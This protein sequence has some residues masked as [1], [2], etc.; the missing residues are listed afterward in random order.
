MDTIF[1]FPA[2]LTVEVDGEPLDVTD[3]L[4]IVGV[5]PCRIELNIDTL[6]RRVEVERE[7]RRRMAT[8]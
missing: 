2:K 6:L 5:P 8:R 7:V 4:R 1:G 3:T